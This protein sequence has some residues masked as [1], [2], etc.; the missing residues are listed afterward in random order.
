[1]HQNSVNSTNVDLLK[2]LESAGF[3]SVN[4]IKTAANTLL[5]PGELADLV[6]MDKHAFELLLNQAEL[7]SIHGLGAK[8]IGLLK[9]VGVTSASELSRCN[10]FD[11]QD[12][13]KAAAKDY[14]VGRMPNRATIE[15]WIEQAGELQNS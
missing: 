13:I 12:A 6:G 9:K 14:Q 15:D 10:P 5:D 3:N 4:M 11:L 2:V 7:L 1:M 8:Y